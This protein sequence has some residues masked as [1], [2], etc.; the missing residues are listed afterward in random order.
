MRYSLRQMQ[1]FQQ[2]ADSLSYTRAAEALNLTQPAVF[3]QVRQLEEQVG[4]PLIERL[5][6]RLF[7]TE[8]GQA[9]LQSAR[10]ILGEVDAMEMRLAELRGLARGRLS[11]AVV[12]TAKYDLPAV[13]GAFSA[14]H[15]GIEVALTVGN[16]RELL[17][18]FAQNADDLYVLGQPPEG[19]DAE[20]EIYAENP[21]VVVAPKGHP[22][23][24]GGRA[25]TVQDLAAYPFLTREEGSGTRRAVE[26]C[27]AQGGVAPK[28]R[29][30]LGA[31]EA[32]K[33]GV[34]AG[35]GLSVLSRGTVALELRHGYLQELPVAG[36]PLMRHWYVAWP[37]ARRKSLAAEAFLDR[38]RSGAG[39]VPGAVVASVAAVAG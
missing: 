13:I 32:V 19:I 22:L 6:K 2:V 39:S 36:F 18:R 12:S 21:L 23:G 16:R 25:L 10:T 26:A 33:Q 31:N 29:M 38:L 15:P 28:V 34:I 4:Q 14:A 3:A 1:I 11:L 5:G 37:R 20:A 30:Q 9:V 8:A 35:L 7:L 24:Q 27:F 17:A